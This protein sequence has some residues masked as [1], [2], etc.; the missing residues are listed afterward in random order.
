MGKIFL[1]AMQIEPANAQVVQNS[2]DRAD[3]AVRYTQHFAE[4]ARATTIG[5][6]TSECLFSMHLT[7]SLYL[8]VVQ[9]HGAIVQASHIPDKQFTNPDPP[10]H[11]ASRR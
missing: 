9:E 10:I 1:R 6:P 2:P 7:N 8:G 5:L 11:V 3:F 4:T